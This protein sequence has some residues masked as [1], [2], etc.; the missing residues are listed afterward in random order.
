M[1]RLRSRAWGH[2]LL[3]PETEDEAGGLGSPAALVTGDAV[4]VFFS[5]INRR[6][7]PVVE[8]ADCTLP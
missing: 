7:E 2:P 4:A 6:A 3:V 8:R 1:A 5:S